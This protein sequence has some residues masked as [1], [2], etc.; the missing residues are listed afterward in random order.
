M[1]DAVDQIDTEKLAD[2]MASLQNADG[3]FNGDYSGEVDTR[4]SYCAIS[5]LS[6]LNKLDKIDAGKARDFIL[7]CQNIDGA[8]GR[9]PGAE[10]HAAYVFTCI[11][12]LKMLGDLDLV[13]KDKLGLWLSRRQCPSG[14]FNG[15]PEKLADVCYSWW[16]LSSCYMIERQQ[17]INLDA[18]KTYVLNCQDAV[19]GGIGDRPGNEV[20]VFHTFFGLTALSLMGH[21]NLELID[22]TY[23]IP[24]KTMKKHF[25]HIYEKEN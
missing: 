9:M 7:S 6:L 4:F 20:D 11:G 1:F 15:R 19:D 5:A 8:F 17:W 3:S 21:Y 14:G 13:D 18:L 24:V 16:I 2:Y 23:A 25:P 10:S 12:S 22:N